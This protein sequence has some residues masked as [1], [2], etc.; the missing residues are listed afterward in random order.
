MIRKLIGFLF[1]GGLLLAGSACTTEVWKDNS[2]SPEERADDLLTKL[3]LEEKVL[4][5]VDRNAPIERLGIQE[6][7]WWNE[8]LHG[9]ARAGRATVFP[10][11]VGMAA[12]FDRDMVLDIFSVV[13]D[14]ARAKHH[15]F[16][17]QGEFGRY[18]GLTM[19][20]PTI[21]IF[22]DPR[23]G[24]GME[25]YGEDPFMNGVL[26]TAVVHGLQGERGEGYDKLHACA[27]HF[28][29]HSGPEWNR[30]SF[31]AKNIKPRDLHETYLPAFKKLVIDGD[32]RMVMCAYNRFEGEPCCSNDQLMMDILRNEWGFD[33]V[34]VS[35][36]WAI[37]DFYNKEAHGT[38]PDAET[39]STDAVLAGTDLN[40]GESYPSLINAVEQGLITEAELDV[41]LKRLLVARFELGEMDPDDKVE[42][43]K[44]PHS[45]VS[46]PEHAT[47]ALDAARKS[48]TLLLNENEA[49]PLKRGGLTVAVMGPNANDS[50]M[51]W[52]NYNGTPASTT[53]ILQGI[54]KA[55]GSDD[56]VIYEQGTEWVSDRIFSSV[57]EQCISE[58]GQGFT[59]QYWNNPDRNG[60]PDVVTQVNSPFH[61]HTGG[62]TVFAPG[63]NLTD[64]SARYTSTYHPERSGEIFFHFYVNGV[65]Q[66]LVDGE[67]VFEYR[68]QHGGRKHEYKMHVEAGKTYDIELEF[69]HYMSEAE[70]DFNI[71]YMAEVDIPASVARV[72]DADVVVFAS[73]I[74]PFLE[75]EEMGVDLPG[76]TGGDRTDIALPAVQ[77]EMLSALHK[78]GKKI[79]LVNCSGSA[80]G[81]EEE[82]DYCSAIL[83]AWYPGQAGGTA[84][85]E[86]LF[87]DY[88]P[89]GRLPVTFYKNVAQLPDFEDYNMTNRTY[90]Y[91]TGEPLF[92]FGYGLSYTSFDYDTPQVSSDA[93]STG[94][95]ATLTVS[96]TNTG[97]YDGEEV[98]QL[99]LQKPDDA[100]GPLLTLRG[101]KRVLIAK[102]ETVEVK[103]QL[104]PEVLEWW[105]AEA[106][107]MTALAG[108][109]R[110]L[111][112]SSSRQEDLQA[113]PLTVVEL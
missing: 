10:Q 99:Y 64:F 22:R 32:V 91:F 61:F 47:M 30:H 25:A 92:H 98:V 23:W 102:G 96:V 103:F 69:A 36:C 87:G 2:Y 48:M 109:Y 110:L 14:E 63:V 50:L 62:A 57:F 8:A 53:T 100:E 78:A 7:N 1:L 73:G 4:L 82:L 71:G 65:T 34:V 79:I 80:I 107:R 88:N 20:T 19:W 66:L 51:Q 72:A 83:Q 45:V 58:A 52:G 111:V 26:G 15:F 39:A 24:R 81:F 6:Y 104:T 93:V 74:S 90:R 75:G 40:C 54:T 21:N 112:G 89:A 16:K 13:S 113:V 17:S 70:L 28:A 9:V 60:N 94:D 33:G 41:S 31:D 85:A 3:T 44:I 37:Y 12:S 105:N 11:P 101:F 56:R 84:V 108:D 5:M 46:S 95:E 49:L 38:H 27:K 18:Q 86:V 77:R 42:W 35:D 106:Q 68:S 67:P 43:S 76:F 97:N 59:A 55:L 29:V